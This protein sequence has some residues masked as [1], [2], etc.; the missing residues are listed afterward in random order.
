V[1]AEHFER[2]GEPERAAAWFRRAAE[3]ALGGNDLQAVIERAGRGL[4]C[5]KEDDT[6]VAI[7]KLLL[8][9]AHNWRAEFRI[10]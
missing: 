2:G 7:L 6:E 10:C 9:E 8:A 4:A 5:A 1:L 3:Q